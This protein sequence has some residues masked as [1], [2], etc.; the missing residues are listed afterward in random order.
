MRTI[1]RIGI[2]SKQMLGI[3]SELQ[4]YLSKLTNE[5]VGHPSIGIQPTLILRSPS[6]KALSILVYEGHMLSAADLEHTKYSV[7]VRTHSWL[8]QRREQHHKN[9]KAMLN[10]YI[11]SILLLIGTWSCYH[12]VVLVYCLRLPVYTCPNKHQHPQ[13]LNIS[14]FQGQV[15]KLGYVEWN[16]SIKTITCSPEHLPQ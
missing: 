7:T 12:T 16:S 9:R 2:L 15:Q 10:K 4:L 6:L 11:K 3:D 14:V 8:W 13:L 5:H 1:T